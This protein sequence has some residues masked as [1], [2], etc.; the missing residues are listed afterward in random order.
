[1]AIAELVFYPGI[2][3]RPAI[4]RN[5]QVASQKNFESY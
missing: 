5:P 4:W 3:A 1:M 2:R